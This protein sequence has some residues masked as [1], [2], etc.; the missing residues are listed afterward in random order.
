MRALVAASG[1]SAGCAGSGGA[2]VVVGIGTV[3]DV[4][5]EGA[6]DALLAEGGAALPSLLHA[7][8]TASTGMSRYTVRRGIE[9]ESRVPPCPI[10]IACSWA[11]V[12]ATRTRRWRRRSPARCSGTSTPSS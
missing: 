5:V 12:R 11:Q 4:A 7:P 2:V 3:V 8:A 10:Q 1:L 9:A 6:L